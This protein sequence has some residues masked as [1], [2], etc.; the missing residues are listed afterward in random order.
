MPAKNSVPQVV[1]FLSHIIESLE[2]FYEKGVTC[3]ESP[4]EIL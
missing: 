3:T 2:V 1:L 4:E